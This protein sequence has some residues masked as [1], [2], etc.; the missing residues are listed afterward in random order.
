MGRTLADN[1]NLVDANQ[2]LVVRANQLAG[3]NDPDDGLEIVILQPTFDRHYLAIIYLVQVEMRNT[4]AINPGIFTEEMV[5]TSLYE[6][7]R[8][9]R[10][11]DF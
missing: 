7:Q 5:L 6:Y 1:D 11:R 3:G 4:V 8:V 2:L 10:W 9:L